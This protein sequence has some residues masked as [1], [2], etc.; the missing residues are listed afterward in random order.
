[1]SRGTTENKMLIVCDIDGTLADFR[2]RFKEAGAMPPRCQR[3][4]LQ[5]W[6]D[7]LQ[8]VAR[9]KKDPPISPTIAIIKALVRQKCNTLLYLTGR[10]ERY[11][12]ATRYW[13][14]KNRC[15]S[16]PLH[17]RT[18]NDWRSARDYKFAKMKE[19][20]AGHDNVIIFDDDGDGDCKKM[21][22]KNGW[23]YYQV[24]LP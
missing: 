4:S 1:M 11:R 5:L 6:L 10:S 3:K 15:P 2:P 20:C 22:A 17:M 9:L 18:N 14:R 8:P 13:L 12:R 19:L 21:Y 23:L 16:A 24:N 7:R